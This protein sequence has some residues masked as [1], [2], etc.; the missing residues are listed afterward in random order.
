MKRKLI[1]VLAL[2]LVLT[3]CGK[4]KHIDPQT[5]LPDNAAEA[6]VPAEDTTAARPV[7]ERAETL[8]EAGDTYVFDELGVL[9][10]EERGK[11]DKYLA[12]LSDQRQMNAAAVITDSLGGE[13]PEAFARDYY[14]TLFDADSTG[15]LLLINNDSGKDIVYCEG[16]CK[17][18]LA[19][20][21]L[22]IS[23]AT[24]LLVE[25]NYADAL[26]ILLPVGEVMPD[27][28][29]DR[30]D[31]LSDEQIL[32]LCEHANSLSEHR[33]VMLTRLGTDASETTEV[34]EPAEDT[35]EET[36]PETSAETADTTDVTTEHAETTGESDTEEATAET[37]V[38]LL[39]V[40]DELQALAD[41][42]RTK[43]EADAIL[44]IDVSGG[45]CALSGE[46]GGVRDGVQLILQK[47]GAFAA[48]QYFLDLGE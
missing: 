44:V 18:F 47:D 15:F 23:Q 30:A 2:A 48:A 32:A 12:W 4:A 40:S 43:N 25:G 1:A 31:A 36:D 3:G 46:E 22:Q 10:E 8:R 29:L 28:V 35:F 42:V 7:S 14:R 11:F 16:A 27:R 9:T 26:E 20:P 38:Q 24:P 39:P 34:P 5:S 6:T 19:D 45:T 37:N 13:T 21:S 33:T 17:Q 41:D